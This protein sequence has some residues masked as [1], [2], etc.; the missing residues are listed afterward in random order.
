MDRNGKQISNTLLF[1]EIIISP[2]EYLLPVYIQTF[3]KYK[4]LLGLL[5]AKTANC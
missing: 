4:L 3:K 1:E 5:K 2:N